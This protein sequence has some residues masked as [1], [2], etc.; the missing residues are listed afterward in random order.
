MHFFRKFC[1]DMPEYEH[2][3][4][5]DVLHVLWHFSKKFRSFSVTIR[6]IDIK[7]Y[8]GCL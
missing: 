6:H 2:L 1:P 8:P 3:V 4:E 7:R 5:S